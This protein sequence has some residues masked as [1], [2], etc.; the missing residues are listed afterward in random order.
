MKAASRLSLILALAVPAGVSA[1]GS[2]LTPHDLARLD[3]DQLDAI[4][5]TATAGE[6][7]VGYGRGRIL[8]LVDGKM[9]RVRARLQGLV[10]KGKVFHADGTF[11]N[12]WTGFQA[13]ASH[14]EAGPSWYDGR[15]CV[16]LAYPPGTPVFGNARDELREVS[17][18]LWLGRF[19]AVC[20]S[21]KLAGYFVLD[22]ACEKCHR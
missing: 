17:S 14:V 15:P 1:D 21:G 2:C 11:V 13:I 16:V 22:M 4:F 18:G 20:P 5:A 10:W 3:R 8:L 6:A 19:Y 9:P 12:Q 7:P